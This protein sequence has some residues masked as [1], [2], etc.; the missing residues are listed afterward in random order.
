MLERLLFRS[1]GT[2]NQ[3]YFPKM[4]LDVWGMR[5]QW[6]RPLSKNPMFQENLQESC[7]C[8]CC[9]RKACFHFF[10]DYHLNWI[11]YVQLYWNACTCTCRCITRLVSFILLLKKKPQ[12][13]SFPFCTYLTC[14]MFLPTGQRCCF[15]A[16]SVSF[17]DDY[18]HMLAHMK[19][20]RWRSGT[21]C[22]T[23]EWAG[24]QTIG[25]ASVRIRGLTWGVCLTEVDSEDLR[26]LTSKYRLRGHGGLVCRSSGSQVLR[27]IIRWCTR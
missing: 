1:P 6:F 10:L 15:F 22:N 3:L 18:Q 12:W 8:H 4:K 13:E 7:A 14:Y 23:S 2:S 19:R 24:G 26:L 5:F 27:V 9:R 11:I 16:L 25:F 20:K 17:V 21:L